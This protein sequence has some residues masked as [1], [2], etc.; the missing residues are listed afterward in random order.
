MAAMLLQREYAEHLRHP[1]GE[2]W[3]WLP[4]LLSKEL[5]LPTEGTPRERLRLLDREFPRRTQ[6]M[7]NWMGIYEQVVQELIRYWERRTEWKR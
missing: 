5:D 3:Q 7:V 4:D 1:V 6:A 2:H